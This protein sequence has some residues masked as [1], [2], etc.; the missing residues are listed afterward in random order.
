M[1]RMFTLAL[2]SVSA[3]ALSAGA[4][5][6]NTVTEFTLSDLNT[7]VVYDADGGAVVDWI[8]NG[9][10]V[11][12][13][14]GFWFRI[15]DGPETALTSLY[16]DDTPV[17]VADSNPFD[18]P[19]PNVLSAQYVNPDI[20]VANVNYTLQGS[21][22]DCCAQ[23]SEQLTIINTSGERLELSIFEYTD[24]DIGDV[25]DDIAE[26][27]DE[28]T[29]IQID[30]G[31]FY[32]ETVLG[33]DPDFW[34]IDVYDNTLGRLN[35]ADADNLSNSTSPLTSDDLTWAAQWDF[36]IPAGGSINLNTSK[37]VISAIPVPA[38]IGLLAGGLLAF[39]AFRRRSRKA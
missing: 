34:E 36:V 6:A 5:Q 33:T 19:R 10:D 39:S 3:A 7:E 24:F 25:V 4:A 18:D 21:A 14:E 9:I 16:T 30:Y 17:V 13:E 20:F 23:L 31:S 2:A 1:T 28:D 11:M 27:K 32:T 22:V 29:F 8:V 12:Y 35:D 26:F 37:Q 38:S 15:G